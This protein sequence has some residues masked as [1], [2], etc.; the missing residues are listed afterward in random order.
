M[1]GDRDIYCP[2]QFKKAEKATDVSA[3]LHHIDLMV[4]GFIMLIIGVSRLTPTEIV[5]KPLIGGLTVLS[6]SDFLLILYVE[7]RYKLKNMKEEIQEKWRREKV[8]KDAERHNHEV[9]MFRAVNRLETYKKQ[10]CTS[11]IFAIIVLMIFFVM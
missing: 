8:F 4:Y 10:S 6:L 3:V 2:E 9:N 1:F 7:R 5:V 11:I